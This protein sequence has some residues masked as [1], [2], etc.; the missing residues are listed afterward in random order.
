MKTIRFITED[1]DTYAIKDKRACVT[2]IDDMMIAIVKENHEFVA[3]DPTTGY[4]IMRTANANFL[5]EKLAYFTGVYKDAVDAG[6]C[7]EEIAFRKKLLNY[8]REHEKN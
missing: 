6:F 2:Y 3:Y 1:N 5:D 7:A 4:Y 8:V